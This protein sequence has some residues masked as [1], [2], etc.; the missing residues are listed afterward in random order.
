MVKYCVAAMLL[1]CALAARAG[2]PEP[3]ILLNEHGRQIV[4]NVPQTRLFVYQDGVLQTSFP[5]AVGKMLTRTPTGSFDVTGIYRNPTW[6]VPKSIQA[7]LRAHGKPVVTEVPPG[8][9]N[10]LGKVF[11]RFGEPGLGLGIHGTNAP[12]SVPGFRSH[13]CVRMKNP[14]ALSLAAM[15]QPGDTVTVA[16]QPILLSQDSA[17]Q[18]WL[19]AYRN[20]YGHD[21]VSMPW[22]AQLLLKWQR[23]HRQVLLGRRVDQALKQRNGKPVCLS[24]HAPLPDYHKATF[25]PL[26]WLSAPPDDGMPAAPTAP[27]YGASED[28]AAMPEARDP[29]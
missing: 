9:D 7:E 11:I 20:P 28:G 3:D 27:H 2:L 16:Y 13:G 18:L 4:I 15:I 1:A 6:H 19:T 21:D 22:L 26:R 10:P 14:D 8:D 12:G 17:G 24:C 29:D 23:D 25:T 5:V